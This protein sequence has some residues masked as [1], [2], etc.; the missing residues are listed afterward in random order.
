MG[1][2]AVVTTQLWHHIY[3][4][5]GLADLPRWDSLESVRWKPGASDTLIRT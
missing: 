2:T 1:M 4:G 5:G 3:C